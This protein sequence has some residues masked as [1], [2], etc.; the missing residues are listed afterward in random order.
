[1]SEPAYV[2][3]E[4]WEKIVLN[5]LS[6]AFKFTFEGEI[7]VCL[8]ESDGAALLT[9]KDTGTGIPPAELPHLFERFHRV[10][11]TVGRTQEGS[12]I[13]LALIQ[14]LVRLHGGS[15][16]VRS[17]VGKGTAF[18]VRIP[19][20]KGHLPVESLLAEGPQSTQSSYARATIAEAERWY[21]DA[22]STPLAVPPN[23]TPRARILLADDN[24][25]MRAYIRSILMDAWDVVAVSNG[26][27]A[28]SAAVDHPPDLVLSDVMMPKLDGFALISRLRENDRTKQVPV[29]LLSARSGEESRIEGLRAGADDYLVKPFSAKELVARIQ[30]HLQIG[31]FKAAVERERA[32]LSAVFA[33]APVGIALLEGPD[34]VF[35]IANAVY[36][37]LLFGGPRDF[38]GKAVKD[39]IPESVPQGFADLLDRV[40]RSGEPF[41]G[42]EM[43]IDLVQKDGAL[44]RFY[45]DF[46]YHP[47]R[48]ANDD[49][50]G[51]VAVI[52]DVTERVVSRVTI[53]DSEKKYRTL[54]ES[55][56][57][58][59]WTCRADGRCDYLS[60]QW[61]NYT[62]APAHEQLGFGWLERAVH[63]EDR[64]RIYAH[65]MGA[66]RGEHGYDIEFRIRR[67][68]GAYRWFKTRATALKDSA[69][70]VS[71]WFGTCTDIQ[72]RKEAEAT[73]TFERNQLE[74]I[75]Q[76]SPAAMAL[77]VGPDLVFERVNPHYQA[78]FPDRQLQGR[79][80]LDACP[81]FRDQP[82]PQLL[83]HV[84]ESGEDF[85][86]REVLARHRDSADGP[87]VDHYYDFTYLR[88]ND[89]AGNPYGVYDHA[90]DVSDRVRDRRALEDNKQRLEK[91]VADLEQERDLREGFVSM[92][93]HDL[94]T[95]LQ[96]AKMSAYVIRRKL[97]DSE[98]AQMFA[99][100]IIENIS[101]ADEMI[102]N[103]LDA[104]RLKAGE[105]LAIEIERC[106]LNEVAAD[107]LADLTTLHGE[108]FILKADSAIEGYWSRGEIRRVIENLC[109]NAIKYGAPYRPVRITLVQLNDRVTIEVQNEGNPISA[110]DRE[111]L[112]RPF[113]RIE[114]GD[115]AGGVSGWGLGLILVKGI[116]EAHGGGVTV[117]SDSEV[118]TVFSVTLPLDSRRGS[119]EP[120]NLH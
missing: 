67:H 105:R 104:N 15:I 111:K 17:E 45:L 83:R 14:E 1:L 109:G 19:L 119:P 58:L 9:V 74:T 78:I 95:P 32:K 88:I 8:T 26:E 97:G 28:L 117:Q 108:R 64:D 112:F 87:P 107:T 69:G 110:A 115:P 33:Q 42:D 89:S 70:H 10:A 92:L 38:V 106:T 16:S 5:L 25:D 68:D 60:Q 52:H 75:F 62:G 40:Y 76:R 49:V 44:R 13:G 7:E 79:A 39:A 3:R 43:P 73:L 23:S 99:A 63:P 55:L 120:A 56:P 102:R 71:S 93:S 116:V 30:T 53:E 31:R 50:H 103:L 2:D 101:R 81:E 66:V 82:F 65:W 118:G 98:V 18:E 91:L 113:K 6:N 48:D 29:L 61:L 96:A 27:E 4:M 47:L 85:I 11:G 37:S 59:V 20:G 51:I 22:E 84:F 114:A 24:A 54:A 36:Y 86:G 100:R 90:I 34:H 12:G 35:A 21:P 72:D 41:V 57:Q 80:F 77:W 94:R 46:V